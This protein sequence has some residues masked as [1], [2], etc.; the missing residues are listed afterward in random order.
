M[1]KNINNYVFKAMEEFDYNIE[2]AAEAL[3]YALAY[4]EHNTMA[5]TLMGRL[6]A[7][8]LYDYETAIDYFKQALGE[9]VNAFEVY[10]P[11]IETLM[12][13]EDFKEANEFIDFAFSVKGVNKAML[14]LYQAIIQERLF[15]YEEAMKKIKEAEKHNYDI[16]FNYNISDVKTRIEGKMPKKKKEKKKKKDSSDSNDNSKD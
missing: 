13:N 6:Y 8:H 12:K 2:F 1:T 16:E 9:K 11:Y 15:K 7:E 10:E 3:N 5:L 4:D 14:Y